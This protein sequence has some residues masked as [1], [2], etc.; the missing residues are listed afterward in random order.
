MA[1]QIVLPGRITKDAELRYTTDGKA[2]S[3]F[4]LAVNDG[5]GEKKATIW[6]KCSL[7]DKRAEALNDFLTKGTPVTVFGRM[8]HKDGNP[9]IWQGKD[10]TNN[11]SFE[12]FVTEIELQGGKR[13][14][15]EVEQDEGIPF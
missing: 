9:R 14:N 8:A 3:N 13:Q 12:V 4:D 5:F 10:G 6:F 7:W 2:V 11:A 15:N 1:H